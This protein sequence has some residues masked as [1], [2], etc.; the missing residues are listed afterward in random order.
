M[1]DVSNANDAKLESVHRSLRFRSIFFW[2]GV[3]LMGVGFF[4]DAL[5]LENNNIMAIFIVTSWFVL[6]GPSV[7][8]AVFGG[9]GGVFTPDYV[10]VT[11]YSDGSKTYEN[12]SVMWKIFGKLFFICLIL[13]IGPILTC[14]HLTILIIKYSIIKKRDKANSTLKPSGKILII[15]DLIFIVAI[16]AVIIYAWFIH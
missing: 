6:C 16:L 1:S 13:I 9:W 12:S 15:L 14:I 8:S 7:K 5:K 3:F 10:K 11:T 2:V 4:L